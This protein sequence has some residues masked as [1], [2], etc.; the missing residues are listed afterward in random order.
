[1]IYLRK[2]DEVECYLHQH[3][4]RLLALADKSQLLDV[5]NLFIYCI[6]VG[7]LFCFLTKA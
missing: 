2:Y 6:E 7:Y 4:S 3:I 5:A 1:M